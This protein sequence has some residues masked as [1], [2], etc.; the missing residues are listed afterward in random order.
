[1]KKREKAQNPGQGRN[2]QGKEKYGIL[3]CI[4]GFLIDL[5]VFIGLKIN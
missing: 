3:R 4:K 1:L 2:S 5:G